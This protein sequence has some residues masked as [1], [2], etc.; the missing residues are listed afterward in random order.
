MLK[1]RLATILYFVV[2]QKDNIRQFANARTARNLYEYIRA[3]C[4]RRIAKE[5]YSDLSTIKLEDVNLD[6]CEIDMIINK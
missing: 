4:T 6:R 2:S 1:K 5:G 3:R